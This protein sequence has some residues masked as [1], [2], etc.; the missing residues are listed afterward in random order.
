MKEKYKIIYEDIRNKIFSKEYEPNERIPDEKTLSQNYSCSKMTIK[1]AVD[2]LVLE[3]LLHKRRG[4][5]TYVKEPTSSNFT[6]TS[7]HLF[8][9]SR[10]QAGKKV[11]SKVIEFLVVQADKI[12]TEKLK[13]EDD[14]FVYKIIRA[15]YVNERPHVLEETYMPIHV[16][17][18][19]KRSHVEGSIYHYIEEELGLTIQSAH[20][21]IRADKPK[22][23]DKEYLL[24]TD[25][26]PV[27]EVE[28]IVFLDDG[29]IFEYSKSRHRYDEFKFESVSVKL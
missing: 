27:A 12:I 2:M 5:G 11:S 20:K 22:K 9:F 23:L 8:G 26:E 14:E 16:I 1:R 7:R 19:I 17:P 15:R 24:L 25:I 10:S 18:G 13:L 29:R 28:Q 4:S 21:T 6:S 3:G